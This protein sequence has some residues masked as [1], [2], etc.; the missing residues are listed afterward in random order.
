MGGSS[1]VGGME[2]GTTGEAGGEQG[3]T[4]GA[5]GGAGGSKGGAGGASGAAGGGKGGSGG[6]GGSAGSSGGSG[7]T[8][9]SAGRSGGDGGTGN[10]SGGGAAGSVAGMSGSGGM[11]V[12]CG[13]VEPGFDLDVAYAVAAATDIAFHADGRAVITIKRGDITVR[14]PDGTKVDLTGKFDIMTPSG[15]NGLLG[16]VSVPGTDDFYFYVS[17]G[18]ATDKNRVLKGT[19]NAGN[20]ILVDSTAVIGAERGNGASLEGTSL[21]GGGLVIHDEHLYVSVGDGAYGAPPPVN[22]SGSC[23]NKP[24]GKILR[25][26]LAG[27]IPIDNPLYDTSMVTSCDTPT[28]AFSTAAPDRR[29]FA[30][31]LRDPARF[32]I[33]PLTNLLWIGDRGGGGGEEIS[34]GPE[35]SHFGWPFYEGTT[36]YTNLA[37]T[38]CATMSPSAPCTPPVYEYA[39]SGGVTGGLIPDGCGWDNVWGGNE[40]YLF[41]DFLRDTIQGIRVTSDHLGL[42]VPQD[43]IDILPA[44]M[45]NGPMSMRM[46]PGDALYV[47]QNQASSVYRLTPK[48]RCGPKCSAN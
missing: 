28:G 7:G 26:D 18:T 22:K 17:D 37:P 45:V 4:D 5:N 16:V 10:A 35:G 43:I 27:N 24:N 9:G 48:S 30:W 31:G 36:A 41:G 23:L 20:D 13:T 3:G 8:G 42:A 21:V 34:V 1:A 15:N 2:A 40:Y 19:L 12:P 39:S 14:H 46:G 44:G 47:V 33:D 32:W 25:V 11:G 29:I 38:S 6:V